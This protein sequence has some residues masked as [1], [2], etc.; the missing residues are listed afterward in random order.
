MIPLV[1][2]IPFGSG[3]LALFLFQLMLCSLFPLVSGYLSASFFLGFLM[4]L[5]QE[6]FLLVLY[7]THITSYYLRVETT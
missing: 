5:K 3:N 2:H 6:Q 7:L 4:Y 1:P